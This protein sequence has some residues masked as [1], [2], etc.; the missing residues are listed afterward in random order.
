MLF[1]ESPKDKAQGKAMVDF[2]N[3]ALTEGQKFAGALGYAPLPADVVKLE[4][5][6]LKKIKVQ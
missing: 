1:Y 5:D 2:M 3:W 4:M 6:A